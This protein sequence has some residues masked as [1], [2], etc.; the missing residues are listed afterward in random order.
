MK[1]GIIGCGNMGEAIIKGQRAKSREQSLIASDKSKKRRDYIRKRCHI[2]VI[3]SNI[4][5]AKNSDVVI[6]AIKPQ[7]MEEVLSEIAYCLLPTPYC[8]LFISIA[9]GIS[10]SFIESFF[11]SKVGPVRSNSRI[12]PRGKQGGVNGRDDRDRRKIF[13]SNYC[14]KRERS[15]LFFLY[16]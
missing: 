14:F 6:L 10:T 13:E 16:C 7:D 9:A 15:G 5:L 3:K 11:K 2:S 4:K 1:I 12:G 8:P